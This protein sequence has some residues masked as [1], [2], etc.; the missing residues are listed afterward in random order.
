MSNLSTWRVLGSYFEVCSCDA[1]CP[2]R[3]QGG[4]T[5][6]RSTYGICDFGLSWLIQEGRADAIDLAGLA[7]ALAGAYN[8]DEPGANWRVTLYVDERADE[9]Q[10]NA[11]ADIFLGRA[12]GTPLKNFARAIGEV[13]AVRPAR[14]TLDH[15]PNHESMTVS[16]FLSARTARPAVSELPVTCGIPG[17]DRPG[18][19][20]VAEHFRAT[21]DPFDWEFTGRCGFASDF[22]YRSDS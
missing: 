20:I 15:T 7:V 19:E 12:G 18:Q 3:R 11:L 1:I 9:I 8:D 5:G 22:D 13:Y 4:Q 10:R 17:H 6:G 14:I 16:G 21:D 2:C